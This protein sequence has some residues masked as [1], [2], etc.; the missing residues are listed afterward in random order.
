MN[1]AIF[2]LCAAS[3]GI[4]E[5]SVCPEMVRAFL[6]GILGVGTTSNASMVGEGGAFVQPFSG[7]SSLTFIG[8]FRIGR[9]QLP[10]RG[11]STQGPIDFFR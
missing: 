2:I 11:I 5:D 9:E 10:G 1:V 7:K 4:R 8:M 6:Q 3:P